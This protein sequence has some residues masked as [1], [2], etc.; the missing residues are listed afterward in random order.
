MKKVN[1]GYEFIIN[2]KKELVKKNYIQVLRNDRTG[3]RRACTGWGFSDDEFPTL[4]EFR[5]KYKV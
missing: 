3:V 2:G 1:G 4:R 5:K